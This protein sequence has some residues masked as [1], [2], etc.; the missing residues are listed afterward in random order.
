MH[1]VQSE[2]GDLVSEPS[3]IRQQTVNLFSKLFDSEQSRS[4]DVEERFFLLQAR[5][6]RQ[7]ELHKALQGMENG[8]AP[9]IDGLPVECNKAFWSILGQ[10]VLEV[11]R[12][13]VEERKLALSCRRAVLTLLPKKGD[14]T[15]LKNCLPVALFCTDCKSLSKAFVSRL[16]K[17]MEQVLH[18][19]QT[20]C[21]PDQEKAF[22]R[23][24]HDYLWKVLEN[25][26]FNPGFIAM[27]KLVEFAG[28]GLN[29]AEDLAVCFGVRSLRVAAKL[30]QCW[31]SVLS[32][33]ERVLI[34]N[35]GAGVFSP[36]EDE[37]FL[38]VTI[39]LDLQDCQGPLPGP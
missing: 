2:S 38:M 26:G 12:V 13:S 22:D 33:E 19:D 29:C 31:R 11:L 34:K 1:A 21:V 15:V 39:D 8:W 10:D 35:Y 30:L 9:E 5:V 6:T 20:Y 24:E 36:D 37:P 27:I 17:V 14:L 18:L 23:V 28:P 32:S 4:Q 16:G 25:F 7:G 3:E